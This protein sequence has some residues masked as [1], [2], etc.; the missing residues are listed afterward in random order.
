MTLHNITEIQQRLIA[1][2]FDVGP[3]GADGRFGEASLA[4]YNR[5]RAS[6]VPPQRPVKLPN[7]SELNRD[8]FPEDLPPPNPKGTIMG[9]ILGNIFTGLFG[10]LLNW[11]LIQGYLRNGL[12][13]LG[14]VL[15]TNGVLTSAELN[16]VVGALM[17]VIS[18]ILSA[19]SNNT[20]K[21]AVDVVKAADAS[22]SVTVIPASE[23]TSG[24][25]I[26][27]AAST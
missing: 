13:S 8:L 22:P 15:V 9:N 14:S 3:S 12:I 7:M 25:P 17:I 26:V 21:K 5:Y 27:K 6:L 23:T 1:L 4:A 19:V 16:T 10:N 24:K 20:K 2:G 18:V 11:Q